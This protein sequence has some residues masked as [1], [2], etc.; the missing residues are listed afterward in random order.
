MTIFDYLSD[1]LKPTWTI[2]RDTRYQV[3]QE[4]IKKAY[5]NK[6]A[7]INFL[8]TGWYK[9]GS[10]TFL[11]VPEGVKFRVYFWRNFDPRPMF[12]GNNEV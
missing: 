8:T 12:E 3:I 1:A 10:D 4:S 5:G 9:I 7:R 2:V 6:C 11:Y